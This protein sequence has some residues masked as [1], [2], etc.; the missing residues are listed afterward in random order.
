[1]TQHYKTN[2]YH[3]S[4]NSHEHNTHYGK[5]IT[6]YTDP[7]TDV[8][9][10]WGKYMPHEHKFWTEPSYLKHPGR[11]Q[12]LQDPHCEAEHETSRQCIST[13]GTL[14]Y[15]AFNCSSIRNIIETSRV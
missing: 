3:K 8:F 10:L 7:K 4:A 15:P 2:H 12:Q 14:H 13:N 6:Q 5:V 9:V 11:I 1:M